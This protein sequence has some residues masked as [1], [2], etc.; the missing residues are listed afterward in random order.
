MLT[1]SAAFSK[2]IFAAATNSINQ[3]NM[4]LISLSFLDVYDLNTHLVVWIKQ[5]FGQDVNKLSNF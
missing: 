2:G 1:T 4:L 5:N 3:T